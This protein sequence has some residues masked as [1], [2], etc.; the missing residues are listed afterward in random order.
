MG[1][2]TDEMVPDAVIFAAIG[3]S[4]SILTG[5]KPTVSQLTKR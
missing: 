5:A 1:N 2:R 3:Q 4:I